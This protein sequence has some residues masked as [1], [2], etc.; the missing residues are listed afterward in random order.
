MSV[1]IAEQNLLPALKD[2]DAGTIALADGFSCRT[3]LEHLADRR[4]W[5]LAELLNPPSIGQFGG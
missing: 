1:A 4:G 2:A 3:Q 5:H